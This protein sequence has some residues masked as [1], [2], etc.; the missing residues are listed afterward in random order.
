[1]CKLTLYSLQDE[2]I[3]NSFPAFKMNY[4]FE[5]NHRGKP[6][7]NLSGASKKLTREALLQKTHEE[8]RKRQVNVLTCALNKLYINNNFRN[9][10]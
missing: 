9:K 2:L 3:N 6:E 5:G 10:D 4:S 8:R 1:M 7:Q